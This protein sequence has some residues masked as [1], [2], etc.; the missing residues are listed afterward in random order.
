[1]P[2]ALEEPPKSRTAL[3]DTEPAARIEAEAVTVEPADARGGVAA[4]A[5][6][7]GVRADAERMGCAGEATGGVEGL[8][9]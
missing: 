6:A 3:G 7:A 9:L 8:L 4:A 1:M 5:A 2:L